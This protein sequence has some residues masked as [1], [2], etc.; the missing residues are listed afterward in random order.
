MPKTENKELPHPK[1]DWRD[2]M[3]K[4]YPADRIHSAMKAWA[5]SLAQPRLVLITKFKDGSELTEYFDPATVEVG[6]KHDEEWYYQTLDVKDKWKH[7]VD[8]ELTL[9]QILK[10]E[11][12]FCAD[13]NLPVGT[14]HHFRE[15]FPED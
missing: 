14:F 2:P 9:P 8:S 15:G 4:H 1:P 11:R 5:K 3:Y 10:A 6:Y 13:M 7:R 12:K